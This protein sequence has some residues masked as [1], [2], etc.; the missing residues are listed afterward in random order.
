MA[1]DLQQ[2]LDLAA[3]AGRDHAVP[4]APRTA[5][6]VTPTSRTRM[7]TVTHHGSSP[8]DDSPTS[9]AP[10][11]A[12]SAIG[13]AILPKSVTSPRL[14]GQLAVEQ[15]GER[16]HREHRRARRSRQRR[17][18]AAKQAARR[19]PARA[20]AAAT[21][22]TLA[23]FHGLHRRGGSSRGHRTGLAS[24]GDQVDSLGVDH[25][26]ARRSARRTSGP[27]PATVVVPS[28]SGPWWAARPS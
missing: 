18:V 22:S 4:D 27:A 13:S 26:G 3:A 28:T 9:A 17:A 12:L 2:G 23:M 8:S 7:T 25:H 1:D 15:V 10:I 6:A 11:S 19:R 21:V 16:R 24:R 20:R 5:A 14:P